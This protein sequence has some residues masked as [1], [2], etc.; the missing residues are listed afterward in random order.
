MAY[1]HQLIAFLTSI[2]LIGRRV[3]GDFPVKLDQRVIRAEVLA[4]G[5][6][7]PGSPPQRFTI[8]AGI[9]FALGHLGRGRS[10]RVSYREA[11]NDRGVFH[12]ASP[13]MQWPA[14]TTSAHKEPEQRAYGLFA[15]LLAGQD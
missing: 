13:V 14:V 3:P 11:E 5:L 8:F 1:H 7:E 6:S 15:E 4:A 12:L 9:D 10:A 2:L